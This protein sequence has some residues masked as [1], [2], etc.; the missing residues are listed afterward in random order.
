MAE[1]PRKVF[2]ICKRCRRPGHT[3]PLNLYAFTREGPELKNTVELCRTCTNI[4]CNK[5]RAAL[6]AVA[7][8]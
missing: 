7:R 3:F 4:E 1:T 8:G 2:Q 5:A 6:R